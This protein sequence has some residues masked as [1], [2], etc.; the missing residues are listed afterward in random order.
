MWGSP[1]P[2]SSA[3]GTLDLWS[4]RCSSSTTTRSFAAQAAELLAEPGYRVS[5]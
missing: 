4:A 1:M 2:M 3:A 5:G